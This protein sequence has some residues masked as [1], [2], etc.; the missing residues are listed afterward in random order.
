MSVASPGEVLVPSF[1]TGPNINGASFTTMG[2]VT[3][4]EGATLDVSGQLDVDGNLIGNGNSGTVFVRGGQLVME[5]SAIQAYTWGQVD[6]A[7]K[8]V[9]IQVSQDVALTQGSAISTLTFG[10]GRGGD[11]QLTA[12]T[13]TMEDRALIFTGAFNDNGNGI[14]GDVVLSVGKVSL[15]G[16]SSIAS[17][18]SS[19]T[20]GL[21]HGNVTIQGLP[22]A[23]SGAAELV[24]LSGGSS[25]S[26]Q[27]FGRGD[28][29]QVAVTATSLTMN[30]GAF[31]EASTNGVGHGGDIV[32]SVQ[33]ASLLEGA[34]IRTITG[35][36]DP[37]APAAATVTVQG[38]NGRMASS[39]ALSGIG[40]GI[41]SETPAQLVLA[42]LRWNPTRS[43]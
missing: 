26:S 37:N 28:G 4:T 39:V 11:V 20:P 3:L 25:L 40:S 30:G 38:L 43:A 22:E 5:A 12:R 33:H 19:F 21:G 8:A 7:S 42:T 9:D 23:E 24:A 17:Q 36:A 13:M 41:I 35:S 10:P 32:V 29:G 34:T 1:Q 6:G 31:I 16:G 18:N 2:T 27:S 14:A 15:M